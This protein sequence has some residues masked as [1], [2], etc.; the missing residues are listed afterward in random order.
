MTSTDS[1]RVDSSEE[2]V[3][4]VAQE[5]NVSQRHVHGFGID[6]F[7]SDVNFPSGLVDISIDTLMGKN[8]ER[9]KAVM[10]LQFIRIVSGS[11]TSK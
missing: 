5:R 7:D 8:P 10:N 2:T 1:T 4:T 9:M 6:P 11:S 3:E